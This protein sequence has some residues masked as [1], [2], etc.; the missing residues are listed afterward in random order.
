M[1]IS[2]KSDLI[3]IAHISVLAKS[4]K[5]GEVPTQAV[6]KRALFGTKI[7]Q[8]GKVIVLKARVEPLFTRKGDGDPNQIH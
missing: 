3:Y 2:V 8:L 5:S 6:K 7:S 4:D 1:V